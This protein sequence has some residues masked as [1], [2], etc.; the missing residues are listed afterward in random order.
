MKEE[1]IKD[2]VKERYSSIAKQ[3]RQSCCAGCD[4]GSGTLLDARAVGYS[5]EELGNIPQDAIMGLG[6]GI[7]VFVTA[8]KVGTQG[9]V[10][11]IDMTEEMVDKAQTAQHSIVQKY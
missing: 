6:C 8:N 1:E 5:S 4:C 10:I 9:K 11:G 7:D 3:S 2:A